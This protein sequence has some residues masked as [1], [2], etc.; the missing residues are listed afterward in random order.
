M[1]QECPVGAFGDKSDFNLSKTHIVFHSKDPH[2]SFSFSLIVSY[3]PPP[4]P[5]TYF[6]RKRTYILNPYLPLSLGFSR[7]AHQN[8]NLSLSLISQIS[9]GL[10]PQ[11]TYCGNSRR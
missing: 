11:T 6:W 4:L 5:S 9:C 8:A 10:C 2:V 3:F 1:K 7:V